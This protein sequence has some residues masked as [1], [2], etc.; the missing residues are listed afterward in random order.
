MLVR[1]YYSIQTKQT[2]NTVL[3][4]RCG[5][6]KQRECILQNVSS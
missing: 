1:V 6:R 4:S 3:C 5:I 2:E